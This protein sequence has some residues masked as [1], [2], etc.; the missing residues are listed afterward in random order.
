MRIRRIIIG[1]VIG[2]AIGAVLECVNMLFTFMMPPFIV[3]LLLSVLA[4]GCIGAVVT[5]VKS[6][7]PSRVLH[8][9]EHLPACAVEFVRQLLKKMRYRRTVRDEVQAE[10]TT[11][12]EDELRDCKIDTDKEQKAKQV[13]SEFGDLKMLAILLRRAKKRCR[14][15][16]RTA[17][18]RAFQAAG[19]LILCLIFYAIWFS[20]G[21]ATIRVDYVALMNR[22]NQPKVLEQDN[23]W[24][25]YEKAIDLYVPQSPTTKKILLYRRTGREREDALWIKSILRDHRQDIDQY[26]TQNSKYWENFNAEQQAVILKCFEHDWVPLPKIVRQKHNDWLVTTFDRMALYVLR[27]VREDA[28]LKIPHPR[29]PLPSSA[30]P[31]FPREELKSWLK[32][33]QIPENFLEAVSVAVLHEADKRYANLPEDISAPL[34]EVECEYLQPWISQNEAAWR[35]FVT[36]SGK[37]YCYRPCS[38]DPND[39][40]RSLWTVLLP[41]LSPLRR[42]T[43]MGIWRSR[44]DRGQGRI[45]QSIEN[46]LAVARAGSHWQG[47]A[48]IVEQLVGIAMCALARDETLRLLKT[49]KLSAAELQNLQNRLSEIYP[50]GFPL[51]N[52]EGERMFFQDVVQRTFTDGGPGGGHLIP[53][54]WSSYSDGS[55]IDESDDTLLS[56]FYTAVS[57]VHAGR[58]ATE[59]KAKELYDLQS[60]IARTTP[61]Q[62]H[63]LDMKTPDE[64][65]FSAN[66]YRYFL[67]ELL[68]PASGRASEIAYRGKMHYEAVLTILALER[69]RLEKD[70][71]P[72]SLNDLKAAG[73]LRELPDDPYSDKSLVYK[74][75]G[76]DCILYS[77]GPNFKDDDGKVGTVRGRPMRWGT[78]ES[79]D[80]VLWPHLK[81]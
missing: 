40:D 13:L 5:R 2:A 18:A 31:G 1:V 58:D 46:C 50:D 37:S 34:S 12:F 47:K 59:A 24:P 69:W 27:C 81:L 25:H 61:Y 14:P 35:E 19:V 6:S 80:I 10:L 67:I 36:G 22:M 38:V 16:W 23:A 73:L 60:K 45:Q 32:N 3:F 43:F 30:G 15:L 28:E 77:V 63:A 21:E 44:F 26:L 56:P 51:M 41:H 4:G 7:A 39:E 71:Y 48:T 70:H 17:V 66:K 29:G 76:D 78:S 68:L 20:F 75:T 79:G 9:L 54:R 57:M 49:E 33:R 42:L 65:F 74:R 52:M 72:A 55:W 53:G 8:D 62:R 11:H 64:I